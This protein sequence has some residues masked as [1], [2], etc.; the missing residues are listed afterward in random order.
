MNADHAEAKA[1]EKTAIKLYKKV[2]ALQESMEELLQ[3]AADL[4]VDMTEMKI[5][6]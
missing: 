6:R 4:R 2:V 1:A 5:L 3:R